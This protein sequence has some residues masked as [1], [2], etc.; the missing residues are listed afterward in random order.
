[1]EDILKQ[2]LESQSKILKHIEQHGKTLN[3]QSEIL[4]KQ[5]ELLEEQ[6]KTL[7]EHSEI[8]TTH[9]KTLANHIEQFNI[10]NIG[11]KK[12]ETRLESE[13]IEKIRALFDAREL[14]NNVNEKILTKL[15]KI[16]HNT[17]YSPFI[18]K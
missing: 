13:L 4:A 1:M 6:Q 11:Q 3:E 12:L 9:S 8:L 2:I 17:S 14:Q 5:S 7:N 18:A 15:E 16:E 10:L